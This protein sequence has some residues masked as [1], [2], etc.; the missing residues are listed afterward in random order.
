MSI[1]NVPLAGFGSNE[2]IFHYSE[3]NLQN[4][5]GRLLTI[6]DASFSD[7]VQRKAVK[8]L[9]SQATWKWQ[10]EMD[11]NPDNHPE[12]ANMATSQPT[13]ARSK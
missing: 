6:I 7:S 4:L 9:I 1:P 5:E 3:S 11:G 8:D 2:R 10:W 12:W 13:G